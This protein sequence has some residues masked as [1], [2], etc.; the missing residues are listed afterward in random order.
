MLLGFIIG[1]DII[2]SIASSSPAGALIFLR[3]PFPSLEKYFWR[4]AKLSGVIREWARRVFLERATIDFVVVSSIAFWEVIFI[5]A[6]SPPFRSFV[7][8]MRTM[9]IMKVTNRSG[10]KT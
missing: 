9:P 8:Y 1:F 5:V 2:L 10:M 7:R 6:F 3:M 4:P